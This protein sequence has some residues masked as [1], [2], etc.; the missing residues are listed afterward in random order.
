MEPPYHDLPF[1]KS[2]SIGFFTNFG[3]RQIYLIQTELAWIMQFL[4]RIY[5][6]DKPQQKFYICRAYSIIMAKMCIF[7]Y[8]LAKN[9]FFDK[10]N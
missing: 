1:K 5:Y 2:S 3:F 4:L 7:K 8:P 6:C 10:A 9:I